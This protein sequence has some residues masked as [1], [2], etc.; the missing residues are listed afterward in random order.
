[1]PW[2][3]AADCAAQAGMAAI[4]QISPLHGLGQGHLHTSF[5]IPTPHDHA[6]YLAKRKSFNIL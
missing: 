6:P 2:E 1:M 5:S 4:S 3:G